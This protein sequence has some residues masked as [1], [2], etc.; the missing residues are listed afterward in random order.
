MAGVP[1]IEVTFDI[2]A[3]GIVNVS[4]KDL[5]TGK[6]Q[7]ITITANN[8]LSDE[9]I[10]KAIHDAAAY[11]H[12]DQHKNEQLDTIG[13][14]NGA[15][16]KAQQYLAENRKTVEKEKK[17]ELKAQIAAVQK[18]IRFKKP[19]KLTDEEAA[20]IRTETERLKEMTP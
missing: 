11:E 9:E 20:N 2:D 13:K 5:G 4:A 12:E 6:E 3:N 18:A 8:K 1:Q 7:S 14:A 16:V 15:I 10:E 17:K 19:E